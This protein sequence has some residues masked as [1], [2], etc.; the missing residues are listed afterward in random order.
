M[1]HVT[2]VLQTKAHGHS[3]CGGERL[4]LLDALKGHHLWADRYDR[5][6]KDLFAVLDD[7]TKQIITSLQV[8][9]THGEVVRVASR[10]TQ[11]FDAYLKEREALWYI[12]QSTRENIERAKQLAEEAIAMDPGFASA[13]RTLGGAHM[14]EALSGLS[15]NPRASL[16]LSDLMLQ[17]A[18]QL[19]GTLVAATALRG[20][21]LVM[22][23]R[24]D[25]GVAEVE[26]A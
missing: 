9:L 1:S 21:V 8:K 26:R 23:R 17:K 16:E 2:G 12:A 6:L 11:N 10:G 22:L 14:M 19:D 5:D 13:Y 20:W 15:K 24:H 3:E 4:Q 25:E 18:F 7:I